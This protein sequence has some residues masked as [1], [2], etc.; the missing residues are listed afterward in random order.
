M[1]RLVAYQLALQQLHQRE[2]PWQLPD[3]RQL[4]QHQSSHDRLLPNQA[5]P[6]HPPA[7]RTQRAASEWLHVPAHLPSLLST[8][9]YSSVW[10]MREYRKCSLWHSFAS[11]PGLSAVL[12]HLKEKQLLSL[13]AC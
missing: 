11:E 4:G 2:Q 6:H 13:K 9:H 5:A 3:T 8:V 12:A 7:A 1:V 10:S